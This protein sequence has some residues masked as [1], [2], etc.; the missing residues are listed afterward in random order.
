[1]IRKDEVRINMKRKTRN[2]KGQKTFPIILTLFRTLL[3][4]LFLLISPPIFTASAQFPLPNPPDEPVKLIFIHHSTGQ[5]WLE[6]GNGNLGW[7]LAEN[8]Y[9]VSDSNY[10]WGPDSIGDRTDIPDWPE[11]FTG[12][13]SDRYLSALYN[14]SDQNS[15]YTRLFPDPGGENQIILF[16]SCFPNSNLEG[17][18]TDAPSA[19]SAYSVGHAK[20]VYNQLLQT[21][22]SRPDKLFIVITAPPV[23]EKTYGTNARAFN[24]WLVNDWLNEND[25]PYQ[26]VAVFDF[27][28]ILTGKNNHHRYQDGQIQ[29]ITDQ[30]KN[31]NAYASGLFDDHPN[32]QGNRKA[33][34]E[35]IPLLNIF[36]QRWQA[37]PASS[38]APESSPTATEAVQQSNTET[39]AEEESISDV[40]SADVQSGN[41]VSDFESGSESWEAFS[42]GSAATNFNCFVSDTQSDEGSAELQIDFEIG[43][44]SWATC[45]QFFTPVRNW[46][47]F[48]GLS[49]KIKSSKSGLPFEIHTYGG[50]QEALATYAFTTQTTGEEWQTVYLSWDD[51][52]RVEWEANPGSPF[53]PENVIGIGF[54]FVNGS[55]TIWVDDIQL[56]EETSSLDKDVSGIIESDPEDTTPI[57]E[58]AKPVSTPV[59]G[60]GLCPMSMALAAAA[61]AGVIFLEIKGQLK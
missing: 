59:S 34:E 13:N 8:N 21:F 60:G 28:N 41:L 50:S 4:T 20:Y 1:M 26:N 43:S 15:E 46:N 52:Q 40:P 3:L 36:Y 18:P 31:T 45:T 38:Q 9:F 61:V 49:L 24:Q 23:Q 10:G 19:Q 11:W 51:L 27:Y 56:L 48:T 5:A 7:T 16:K 17:S 12:P 33:T 14:E 37:D 57:I 30:G 32:Q 53:Q 47:T 29:H 2:I 25:Y 54:G 58:T 42:D 39:P 6:D 44:D 22:Q 55:G 35:F